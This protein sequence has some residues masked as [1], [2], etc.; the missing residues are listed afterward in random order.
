MGTKEQSK[1]IDYVDQLIDEDDEFLNKK[2]KLYCEYVLSLGK[3]N[4]DR[5]VDNLYE[6]CENYLKKSLDMRNMRLKGI[7]N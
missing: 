5:I 7:K 3:V 2:T 4:V 1:I 6:D